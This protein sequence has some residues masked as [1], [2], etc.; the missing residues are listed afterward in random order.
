MGN[1]YLID[2]YNVLHAD[3]DTRGLLHHDFEAA[4]DTLADKVTAFCT[5]SGHRAK[6]V[7]DGRGI[8]HER[9][10]SPLGGSD[11]EVIYG[12]GHLTADTVIE[13][14]VYNAGN[15]G[16]YIVVSG[17]RGVCDTCQHM[18]AFVMRPAHFFTTV[19]DAQGTMR[20]T[21]SRGEGRSPN[22]IE[23]RLDNDSIARLQ[24]LKDQLEDKKD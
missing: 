8:V 17:D 3:P 1:V 19:R 11:V 10:A 5:A 15:R 2:G 9:A 12:P 6:L 24:E 4:R 14:L 13:R 7:F 16:K 22:F 23:D 21:I 20:E 18:G